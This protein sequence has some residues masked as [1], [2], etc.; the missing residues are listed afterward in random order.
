MSVCHQSDIYIE[1]HIELEHA[2]LSVAVLTDRGVELAEYALGRCAECLWYNI[3]EV[4]RVLIGADNIRQRQLALK[5][6][7]IAC[8]T[9]R[10]VYAVD[11]CLSLE[12]DREAFLCARRLGFMKM[13]LGVAR[14]DFVYCRS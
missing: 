9:D 6:A 4:A 5:A 7:V 8:V 2:P 3:L 1:R 10:L 14:D 12:R 11:E 13:K